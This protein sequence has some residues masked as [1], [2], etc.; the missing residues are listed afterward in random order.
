MMKWFTPQ[1]QEG[2]QGLRLKAEADRGVDVRQEVRLTDFKSEFF[3]LHWLYMLSNVNLMNKKLNTKSQAR[4]CSYT[5]FCYQA[6]NYNRTPSEFS[7]LHWTSLI[8]SLTAR[9]TEALLTLFW[10]CRH[11]SLPPPSAVTGLF[12]LLV[13]K[14]NHKNRLKLMIHIDWLQ[15]RTLH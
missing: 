3:S 15:L 12:M 2:F 1:F 8:A 10:L 14:E 13:A 11:F 4:K 9:K 7:L 6:A 5:C